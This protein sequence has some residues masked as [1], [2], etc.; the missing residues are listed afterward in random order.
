MLLTISRLP[1]RTLGERIK[2]LRCERGLTQKEIAQ[3]A[4]VGEMT[5]VRWQKDRTVPKGQRL[6]RLLR[7][8]ERQAEDLHPQTAQDYDLSERPSLTRSL[9]VRPLP[10]PT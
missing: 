8:L 4:S 3:F 6:A 10:S 1:T 2:S 9:N 7:A 5:L